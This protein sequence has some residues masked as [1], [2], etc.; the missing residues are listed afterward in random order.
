MISRILASAILVAWV[1][2]CAPALAPAP[3]VTTP[4]HPEFVFP[5]TP[6]AVLADRDLVLRQQRGWQFLQAGD[7]KGA[8]REFGAALKRNAAFYP[9]EAGLA[10]AS[11]ADEDFADAVVRF[12][13]ALKRDPKY[14][15]ALVGRGDALVGA[16][17]MEEG[18]TS[19][20]AALAEDS[21]LADVRRRLDVLA[22]RTQQDTLTR[23]RQ[24]MEAG[25]FDEAA[26]AYSARS[27][28]RRRARF[29]I[30]NWRRLSA[31]RAS[32]PRRWIT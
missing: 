13:W 32:F 5:G 25:R 7:T 15:P 26:R 19:F 29:S 3:V 24:A 8:R 16:G 11:L 1:A 23:A 28:R 10:Y 22:L 2:S 27:P 20:Q 9:A 18:A 30:A 14:I 21:S 6:S 31:G 17:R 12:D 4:R